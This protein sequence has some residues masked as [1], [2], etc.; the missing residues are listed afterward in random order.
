VIVIPV[1]LR[2][3]GHTAAGAVRCAGGSALG[4]PRSLVIK[5]IAYRRARRSLHRR[6]AGDRAR[7]R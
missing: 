7:R 5:R 4:L 1:V 6:A 3:T 2:T